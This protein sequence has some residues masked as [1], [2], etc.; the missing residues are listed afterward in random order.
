MSRKVWKRI[1]W[2]A[3]VFLILLMIF[4]VGLWI[5]ANVGAVLFR[6]LFML[7]EELQVSGITF[8][9]FM[10]NFVGSPLFYMYLADVTALVASAAALVVARKQKPQQ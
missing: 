4:T 8:A 6:L 9:E 3:V 5:L 2:I 1:F 7:D 10:S